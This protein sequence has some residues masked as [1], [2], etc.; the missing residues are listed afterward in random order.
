MKRELLENNKVI[1]NPDII[2]RAGFLSAV[3]GVKSSASI[4]VS[5]K[6]EHCDTE[7]GTFGAV[8][9]I[10]VCPSARLDPM[11]GM[12]P[13]INLEADEDVNI[14]L[15]LIGCKRFVKITVGIGDNGE[16]GE[17]T[18]HTV[19]VLGDSTEVPV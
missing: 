19:I 1:I 12:L 17:A 7:D 8:T 14:D 18:V 4:S 10:E 2:D 6:L 13:E 11:T 9:D 16:S 5:I 15:D 3:Y